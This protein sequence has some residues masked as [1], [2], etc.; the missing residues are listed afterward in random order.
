MV[1]D[2]CVE[3]DHLVVTAHPEMVM[4]PA[5]I[6]VQKA[7]RMAMAPVVNVGLAPTVRRTR[8]VPAQINHIRQAH[9]TTSQKKKKATQNRM[10]PFDLSS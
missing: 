10:P 1:L 5:V 7:R 8:Q 3:T 2:I 6:N 4:K 9:L